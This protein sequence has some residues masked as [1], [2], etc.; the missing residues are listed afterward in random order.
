MSEMCDNACVEYYS[1]LVQML[2]RHETR[3][4]RTVYHATSASMCAF[5]FLNI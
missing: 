2:Y 1:L 5:S 4:P 3:V